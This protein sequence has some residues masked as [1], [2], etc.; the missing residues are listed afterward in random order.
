[1]LDH[2]G[3]YWRVSQGQLP[4]NTTLSTNGEIVVQ[5]G[6][7]IAGFAKVNFIDP[8][9]LVDVETLTDQYWDE[10]MREFMAL[11]HDLDYEFMVECVDSN[12]LVL[13]THTIR[14]VHTR[15]PVWAR[16]FVVNQEYLT[17]NPDQYYYY[18]SSSENTSIHWHTPSGFLGNITNGQVSEFS[19]HASCN[20]GD[21]V[22]IDFKPGVANRFP[23]GL[24]LFPNGI[25]SGRVSFRSHVDDPVNIPSDFY[26]F[27]ARAYSPD[28]A[29][30]AERE[31][32]IRVLPINSEPSNNIWINAY[33]YIKERLFFKDIMENELLFPDELLYRPTDPWF[34]KARKIR[35]LFAPGLNIKTSAEYETILAQNHYDKQ[36]LFDQVRTAVC[37]DQNLNIEYEVVY[38]TLIDRMQAFDNTTGFYSQSI[39][40]EIDLRPYISNYY[41]DNGILYYMLQPNS[42]QNMRSVLDDNV[43][44]LNVGQIPK[45]MTSAQ[46]VP[47]RPGIFTNGIGFQPVVVLA[48]CLPGGSAKIAF[49]L[50]KID[51]NKISFEFDRYQLENRMSEYYDS[52]SGTYL[53]GDV[54]NIDLN[55]TVF[56]D[57]TTRFVENFD[58]YSVP[59]EGDKYLKFPKTKAFR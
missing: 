51:W 17:F 8:T 44:F 15:P 30:F 40:R 54:T 27:T 56:D 1:M 24:K 57:D 6:E 18:V 46:P 22:M 9:K 20:T 26:T 39:P 48:Y 33:P 52:D 19:I 31:F 23:H 5:F 10:F 4:P 16:W 50:Q 3:S 25:I 55:D 37:L 21:P 58:Y 59:E 53:P 38:L 13:N 43:G 42:L 36:L 7:P 2:P 29:T 49:N 11:S 32:S 47:N 41:I 28:Y 34:G 12:N 35:V 14:I 45:W